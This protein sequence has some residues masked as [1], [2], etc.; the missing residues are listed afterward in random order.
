MFEPKYGTCKYSSLFSWKVI[1]FDGSISWPAEIGSRPDNT[2][3]DTYS[4]HNVDFCLFRV[5]LW[6]FYYRSIQE[7]EMEKL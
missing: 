4:V 5:Y 3:I 6:I 1:W 7:K 2:T